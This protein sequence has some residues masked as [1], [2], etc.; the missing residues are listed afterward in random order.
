MTSASKLPEIFRFFCNIEKV[1]DSNAKP[2]A[3]SATCNACQ[4]RIKGFITVTSNF[5]KHLRLKHF[6]IHAAFVSAKQVGNCEV[7]QLPETD[8]F[9]N[10]V[11]CYVIDAEIPLSTVETAS[12]RNLFKGTNLRVLSRS[13]LKQRLDDRFSKID[14]EGYSES[15][16]EQS[17]LLPN[18]IKCASYILNYFASS[19]FIQLLFKDKALKER[20]TKVLEKCSSL[21]RKCNCSKTSETIATVLGESL[22]T[23]VVTRWNSTYDAICCILSH[24]DKLPE[25]CRR[26]ALHNSCF[27]ASDIQYMEEYRVLMTPIASTIEFLQMENNLFYGCLIPAL[28]SLCVKLKRVSDS[29]ELIDLKN[30]AIGMQEKLKERFSKYVTLSEDAN[31]AII[32]SVLCPSVKMRWFN[33]LAKVSTHGRSADDI[34][35]I[36]INEAVRHAKASEN[37][38]QYT[39][40][41][42]FPKRNDDFYEFDE[43]DDAGETSDLDTSQ[44][45]PIA[46]TSKLTDDVETQIH[47]YLRDPGTNFEILENKCEEGGRRH[48]GFN[49]KRSLY[50]AEHEVKWHL[51]LTKKNSDI[52]GNEYAALCLQLAKWDGTTDPAKV[53]CS[54]LNHEETLQKT[55]FTMSNNANITIEPFVHSGA[56]F[57]RTK[58]LLPNDVLTIFC[59]IFLLTDTVCTCGSTKPIKVSESKISDDFDKLF[60]SKKF[61]DVTIVAV[62]GQEIQAHKN[63]LSARCEVF[64]A[65]FNNEMEEKLQ[66]RVTITDVDPEVLTEMLRFIYTDQAPKLDTMSRLTID[67]AADT[68]IL[69]NTHNASQLQAHTIDFINDK[70]EDVEQTTGW[71]Q[72][73]LYHPN[74]VT[75]HFLPRELQYKKKNKRL[76]IPAS[77]DI[78]FEKS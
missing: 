56:L 16:E 17:S 2:G 55:R 46:P 44:P 67:N 35:K 4:A 39:I 12:F 52:S 59:E 1:Q 30:V 9:D 48:N 26:L 41:K 69:A 28:T 42:V 20:H 57:D 8:S 14:G 63:I 51:Q 43:I 19:D 53:R 71:K 68:L 37:T 58:N 65:M 7:P 31:S 3:I 32:A 45:S 36:I 40:E 50:D 6:E 22:I 11:M 34:H 76:T 29:S 66:G 23:P 18:H 78:S 60:E 70:R 5:I 61:S 54:I 72:M 75:E 38:Y 27:S 49:K 33:A 21:W 15:I 13:K 10:R 64:E 25:L 73:A 62:G 47:N 24:K 74:L 77:V